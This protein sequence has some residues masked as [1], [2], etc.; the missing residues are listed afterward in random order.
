MGE[1]KG[2][3]RENA[4][5]NGEVW[6]TFWCP[7]CNCGHTVNQTWT[8]DGNYDAPTF[9]PSV[10]AFPRGQ[11]IDPGLE[12]DALTA[13]ENVRQT[14]RCHSFVRAG[15]I[16]FLGDCEHALAGQTVALGPWP[17]GDDLEAL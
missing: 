2:I 1:T 14:P 16:E 5:S 17:A 10:L 15:Q 8:F 11:F 3:L 4:F 12:G 7:G 6:R 9:N 13:P